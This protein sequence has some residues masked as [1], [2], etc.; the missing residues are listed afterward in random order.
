V[1]TVASE[2]LRQRL[3]VSGAIPRSLATAAIAFVSDEYDDSD[4][5]NSLTAFAL[6]SD[7][8][9]V[10]FAMIPSS[11]IELEEMRNKKTVHIT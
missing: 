8:Y 5:A 6:N 7:V 9:L 3:N 2:W 11:S 10:P 1:A 4:S